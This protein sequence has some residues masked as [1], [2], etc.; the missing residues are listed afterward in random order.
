MD[1]NSRAQFLI[2]SD[3]HP[4]P[5]PV[6]PVKKR[7]ARKTSSLPSN[8]RRSAGPPPHYVIPAK[9]GIS[10][11]ND[12]PAN[13]WVKTDPTELSVVERSSPASPRFGSRSPAPATPGGAGSGSPIDMRILLHSGSAIPRRTL[14][15]RPMGVLGRIFGMVNNR[16]CETRGKLLTRFHRI[17]NEDRINRDS[18]AGEKPQHPC[19]T[20]LWPVFS[21]LLGEENRLQAILGGCFFDDIR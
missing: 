6:H 1:Y 13:W 7:R 21:I 9:A 17:N 10:R 4:P 18:G 16:R 12:R 11:S 15:T 14:V 3:Q 5:N 20:D 8:A 19:A 2:S